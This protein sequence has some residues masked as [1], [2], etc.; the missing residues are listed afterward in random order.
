VVLR[1]DASAPGGRQRIP[2]NLARILAGKDS[3]LPL[4]A[5]DMLFVPDSTSKR[6]LGR[7]AEAALQTITGL[8]I[9]G[10]F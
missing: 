8:A 10:R 3:D 2:V 5:D 7:G 1:A 4:L 9:Y 6:A